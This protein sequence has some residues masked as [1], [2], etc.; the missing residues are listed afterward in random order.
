MENDYINEIKELK[1]LMDENI[2]TQEE[3]NLKKNALL[4][5]NDNK[6]QTPKSNSISTNTPKQAIKK[7]TEKP[8]TYHFQPTFQLITSICS[9]VI[10]IVMIFMLCFSNVIRT[11]RINYESLYFVVSPFKVYD[12]RKTFS[13]IAII[14]MGVSLLSVAISIFIKNKAVKTLN[15]IILLL[16]IVFSFLAFI[17]NL[18]YAANAPY[19]SACTLIGIIITGILTIVEFTVLFTLIKQFLNKFKN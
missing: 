19:T 18:T 4:F 7:E 1:K 6:Q 13:I 14:L 5:G 11:I 2:I 3:F 15:H 17:F 16:T 10:L 12:I 8:Q 9:A